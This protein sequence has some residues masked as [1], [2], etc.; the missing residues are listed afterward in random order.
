MP[1]FQRVKKQRGRVILSECILFSPDDGELK[2]EAS[3]AISVGINSI[4]KP[5]FV[6]F[7]ILFV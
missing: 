2:K 7:L 6:R 3:L 1:M 4:N 5:C